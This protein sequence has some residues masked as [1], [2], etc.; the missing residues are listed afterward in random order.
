LT[1]RE[2]VL[3]AFQHKPTDKVPI[4]NIG[5]SSRIA[6]II[7]GREAYVGGGV[8][9]W[10]EAKALWE[11]DEAHREYLDRSERD[12]FDVSV[13]LEHDILRLQYWRMSEKP[14]QSRNEYTYLYGD[15][16]RSW[17]LMRFDP[18]TELYQVIDRYPPEAEET[19]ESIEKRIAASER[20]LEN[21]HP[22][23]QPSSH[24]QAIME[25]Y[26]R[27][28]VV[29]FGGGSLGIPYT[30]RAWLEAIVA[31]PDLIARYLDIEA[32]RGIR[33]MPGIAAAGV[34][35]LFGG[36]DFAADHGP[37]YS[38]KAFHDLMLPR[39]KRITEACHKHG[40]YYLFAS[41]GNL[42]PLADDLFGNSGVDGFYEIDGRAGMDLRK[43][44]ERFPHLVLIGNISSH[45][46]HRGTKE[47][48]IRETTSCLDEARRSL[49]IIV[50]VSNY[51][52]PGTPE[53]NLWAMIETMK[54]FR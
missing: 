10:R 21:Y 35:M 15:P 31:R 34:K 53:E 14:T 40:L 50:G 8:Q 48:V 19:Y 12:A 43:L 17:R 18:D 25:N 9:Q 37:F 2:R 6:S 33:S 44:R 32:E 38:P 7:L 30:S 1:S 26:G 16:D 5:F 47:D 52:L 4:H 23:P 51:I 39:L 29:R 46:L 54:E 49:G 27:K 13:K 28:W 36:G 22:S 42:W 41:D 11:G 24:T 20:A 45:T 3:A